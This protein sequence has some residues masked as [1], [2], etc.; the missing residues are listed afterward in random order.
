MNSYHCLISNFTC[1]RG[2]TGCHKSGRIDHPYFFAQVKACTIFTSLGHRCS[3]SGCLE[4][5]IAKDIVSSCALSNSGSPDEH[6]SNFI[7]G[8]QNRLINLFRVLIFTSWHTVTHGYNE[9]HRTGRPF[10][11]AIAGVCYNRVSVL[12]YQITNRTFDWV[13]YYRVSL[14]IISRRD[15]LTKPR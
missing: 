8:H 15:W 13:R 10:L 6:D 2:L 9:Q 3:T 12:K 1:M 14:Y 11:S 4:S 7:G 5:F